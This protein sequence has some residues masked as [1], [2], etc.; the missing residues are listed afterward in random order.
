MATA[1]VTRMA[2]K[3]QQQHYMFNWQNNNSARTS[4]IFVHFVPD[5]AQLPR[6]NT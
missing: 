3:Q 1:M 6:A 5:T 2:K 4:H